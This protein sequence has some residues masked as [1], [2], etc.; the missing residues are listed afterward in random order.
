MKISRTSLPHQPSTAGKAPGVGGPRGKGFA[1][2]LDAAKAEGASKD[3]LAA[4]GASK[5]QKSVVVSDIGAALK[6]GK[7][8]PQAAIDKVIE[9]V[10][11]RQVG[12]KA[13]AAV[14][15]KL[16]AALRESL[17]DDPMLAAKVRALAEE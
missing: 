12:R 15:E 3:A 11:D 10:L 13:G 7:L 2:K 8:T 9:R 14:R 16:S 5:T 6:A 1:A 4:S 17:A